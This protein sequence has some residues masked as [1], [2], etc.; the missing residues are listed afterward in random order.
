[1]RIV[2]PR[3]VAAT[4]VMDGYQA[5]TLLREKGFKNSI[6]AI[7][8]NALADKSTSY[9]KGFDAHLIKP[10]TGDKLLQTVSEHI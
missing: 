4:S 7:T 2:G 10:I 9:N 3:L 5:A 6:I 1:M 8:A